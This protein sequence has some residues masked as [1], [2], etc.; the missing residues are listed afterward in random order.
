[1]ELKDGGRMGMACAAIAVKNTW[2]SQT[3]SVADSSLQQR[4]Y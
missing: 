3:V 2:L 1:M 4:Y